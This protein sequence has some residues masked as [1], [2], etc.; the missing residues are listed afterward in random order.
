MQGRK[1]KETYT[2][3]NC[4][5]MRPHLAQNAALREE[6]SR[7][8]IPCSCAK[9]MPSVVLSFKT[10]MCFAA[11]RLESSLCDAII[12]TAA[13]QLVGAWQ[14]FVSLCSQGS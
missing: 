4:A 6:T 14:S 2:R 7:S 13:L 11:A 1:N 10:F 8:H 12:T 5:S 3:P 9:K